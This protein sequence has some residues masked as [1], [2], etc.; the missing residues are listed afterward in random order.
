MSNEESVQALAALGF[1][2]LEAEVYVFLLG[3]APATG[4]RVAQAIGRLPANTYKALESLQNKGAV[5]IDEGASRLCRAIPSAELLDLLKR[6]FAEQEARAT[7]ALSEIAPVSHD[8]R[9]YQLRSY[10]QV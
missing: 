8:D 9:I 1:T 4:Y 5:I 2:Q 7:R 6:R 3:E 10:D